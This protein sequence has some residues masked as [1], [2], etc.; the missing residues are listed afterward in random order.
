MSDKPERLKAAARRPCDAIE[1]A[2]KAVVVAVKALHTGTATPH[3]QQLAL[4]WILRTAGAKAHFPYH[5]NPHDTAFAL[6]RMFVADAI[7]GLINA[8]FS[9]LRRQHAHVETATRSS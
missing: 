7:V 5:Q 3:Q 1:P 9:S 2:D 8:D 4:E 6:G